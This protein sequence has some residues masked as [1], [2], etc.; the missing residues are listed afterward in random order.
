MLDGE[1]H[2][3]SDAR[4]LAYVEGCGSCQERLERLTR[5]RPT[6]TER[7]PLG[8]VQTDAEA[9][10]D[11]ARD[12]SAAGLPEGPV[13]KR[14]DGGDTVVPAVPPADRSEAPLDWPIIPGYEVL[15]RLGAG[16]MG[17]VYEARHR[18]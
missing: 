6:A 8:T 11:I 17:I 7:D 4:I 1:L 14:G 15:Q 16:G 5:G 12:D 13:R 18:G 3:E 9:P 2:V 10:V